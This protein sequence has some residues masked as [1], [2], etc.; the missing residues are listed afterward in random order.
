MAQGGMNLGE[1]RGVIRV[2]AE[3]EQA[4]AAVRNF[5]Q[6]VERD[7]G[8]LNTVTS[9]TERTLGALG[10]AVRGLAGSAG[11]TLGAAGA[12]QIA[13]MAVETTRLATAYDRQR[14]AATDLAG[15]QGRLTQLLQTYDAATGGAIGSMASMSD[16]TRLL[17]IGFADSTEELDKFVRAARGISIATG[18]SQEY[19]I[20]QLQ[21]A[22]ANQS[23]MRL[24]QL[25]LGVEEVTTR[26]AKLRAEN[27]SLSKEMAYQQAIL[28]IATEK[29]GA[30]TTSTAG[31]ATEVER[32]QKAWADLRLEMGQELK[33]PVNQ[34]A[35]DMNDLLD[36]ILRVREANQQLSAE[37]VGRRA[38]EESGTS[39]SGPSFT[40]RPAPWLVSAPPFV[41]SPR[42]PDSSSDFDTNQQQAIFDWTRQR[43]E[44]EERANEQ[45]LDATRDYNRQRVE[46]ES[47]YG[48]TVSREA[49][50]FAINRARQE[51]QLTDQITEIRESGAERE[52][53]AAQELANNIAELREDASRQEARWVR[54][55]E[56]SLNEARSQSAKRVADAEEDHQERIADARTDSAEKLAERQ[57]DLDDSLADARA[58]SLKRLAELEQSYQRTRE[59]AAR[60][61]QD[62]IFEAAGRLDARA[63]WQEQRRYEREEQERDSAHDEAVEAERTR[64]AEFEAKANEAH[65]KAVSEEQRRL[66]EFIDQQN[67]AH[68]ERLQDEK[69]NLDE[70]VKQEKA[71]HEQRV[72]DA[73]DALDQRLSDLQTAHEEQKAENDR[74]EDERVEDLIA[75][76]KEAKEQE[77]A[78][79]LLR[80][81]RLAADHNDQLTEMDRV[82]GE[83]ITQ[84][85]TQA[86]AE[87][88]ALDDEFETRLLELGLQNSALRTAQ[89][90]WEKDALQS[91]NDWWKEVNDKIKGTEVVIGPPTQEE[92]E[93]P[94]GGPNYAA[95]RVAQQE[96]ADAK[97]NRDKFAPGTED[98]NF[99]ANKY[100][101]ADTRLRELGGP[102]GI[103]SM[104]ANT[105]ILP[106]STGAAFAMPQATAGVAGMAGGALVVNVGGVN[107][108][109]VT[110]QTANDLAPMVEEIL[111]RAVRRAAGNG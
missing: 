111:Y 36:L 25:G 89:D 93:T 74:A 30:L 98:W 66:Q 80:L 20:S 73:K 12:M 11:L 109:G 10:G 103:G 65:A 4:R 37:A 110:G 35:G 39:R 45:S 26:I 55:L 33:A 8:G 77:D 2:D 38:A 19:I 69:E 41:P 96:A 92:A 31:Q 17:A 88:T 58:E 85:G 108:S 56:R 29:F 22:I 70:R 7:L 105:S 78:D 104:M 94:F 46:A 49:Q 13:R 72:S 59:Q 90:L 54:D 6:G 101:A 102:V 27:S 82:H 91:F 99:W 60:Q 67:K 24:D 79:R 21:L 62:T 107:I 71:A 16:V 5:A 68:T 51:Q 34:A 95:R 53:R 48:K 18:Q 32:L 106:Q 64:L 23:T 75:H 1:A 15:S 14:L 47:S 43:N 42:L 28:D 61:H 50:D 44:I 9:R 83:R 76:H 100:I 84:I 86:Q 3:L 97:R 57:A 81:Q 63:V 40:E 52:Q 87:R